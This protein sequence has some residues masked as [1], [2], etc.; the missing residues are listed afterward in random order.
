MADEAAGCGN[1]RLERRLLG[2]VAGV[3]T[4][5]AAD[6]AVDLQLLVSTHRPSLSRPGAGVCNN[7]KVTIKY[8]AVAVERIFESQRAIS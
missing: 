7:Q 1:L 8:V 2:N 5:L 6:P 4:L 3:L